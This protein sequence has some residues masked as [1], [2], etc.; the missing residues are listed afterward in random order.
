MTIDLWGLGLQAVNVL[1][2]VWLLSR[3]FWRPVAAA[4]AAR[5]AAAKDLLAKAEAA[6]TSAE[7]ERDGLTK[8]REAIA[9]ERTEAL[10]QAAETA[11][12]AA[13]ALRDTA[14]VKAEALLVAA[15]QTSRQSAAKARFETAQDAARLAG[16]LASRLLTRLNRAQVQTLFQS[17]FTDSLAALPAA[18]KASLAKAETLTLISAQPLSPA[19]RSALTK[20]AAK[21]LDH[22]VTLQFETDPTLIAGFQLHSAHF[23]L[24]NSWRAD[25]DAMLKDLSDAA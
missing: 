10:A 12:A 19:Q 7:A 20:G 3:L 8:A 25:L 4:I 21:A 23:V 24:H 1:V 15:E 14:A 6:K 11:E 22:P 17:L 5:Q 9:T 13:K 16:D 2:L 18:D